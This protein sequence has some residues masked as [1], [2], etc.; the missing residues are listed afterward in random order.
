MSEDH[1]VGKQYGKFGI[2]MQCTHILMI[3]SNGHK[4][5]DGFISLGGDPLDESKFIR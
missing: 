4:V 2:T 3:D 5:E 1:P